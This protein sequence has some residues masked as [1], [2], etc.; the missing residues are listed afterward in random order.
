[1]RNHLVAIVTIF[2]LGCS[3]KIPIN[4]DDIC[5]II[6]ENP[7]WSNSLLDA[8]KKWN[9]EP[10]TVMAIIRQESSFNANAAPDREK[11][12][13]FIPWKRP[14]SAR[15]YSQAV[16]ATWE[17]Y[18]EETGNKRARRSSFDSSVDFIGWYLSKASSARIRSYEVD[19]LYIAYHEGYGGYK[20]KSFKNKSWLQD[21]AKKVKYNSVRYQR[22]LKSCPLQRESSFFDI[23]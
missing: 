9:A 1:M 19:K 3:A 17:Q 23:F 10:S 22:Q 16:E 21:I 5:V 20:R 7:R 18:K 14:S 13:G 8:K 15:G 2:L 11:V 4:Q 12:L 6:D